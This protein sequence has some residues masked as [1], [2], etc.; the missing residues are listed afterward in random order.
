[1][2]L[3][4]WLAKHPGPVVASNQA[5]TRILDL[6]GDLGFDIRLLDAPRMI[7]CTGDRSPA[8]EMLAVLGTDAG[9]SW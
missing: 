2:R 1:M 3:A 5:T 9:D 6:Y 7:S 4:E 8:K